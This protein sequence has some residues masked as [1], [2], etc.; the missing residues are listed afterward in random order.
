[1]TWLDDFAVYAAAGLNA[2][3]R[4]TLYGRGVS[5]EQMATF[6]IGYIDRHLPPLGGAEEFFQW[7]HQG[8]KLDDMFVFPLTTPSGVIGG[9]QFRHVN[10]EKKGYTD[11]FAVRDEPCLF[12]L[13]QAVPH[14]WATESAWL[15][16]GVFDLFPIQRHIG[17]VFP[18]MTAKVGP[19]IVRL[20]RRLVRRVW[21]GYD[22][23]PPGRRAA[24]EFA[25]EHGREFDVCVVSYPKLHKVGSQE[26]IK[27]P[28]DLWEIWGDPKVGDFVRAITV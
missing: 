3:H 16:E 11:F 26:W 27:D 24:S 4:E 10:R 17:A 14:L 6:Q 12:G 22:M 5:D 2:Q 1:M 25:R 28:G 7:S 8:K 13:A 19:P 21:L 23:D 9:F 15:V 18:T 20:L